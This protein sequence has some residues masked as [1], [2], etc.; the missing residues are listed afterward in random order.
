[1]K[2]A[3]VLLPLPVPE[4]FDYEVP[5][6]LELARGDQ[7]AVPLGPRLM[8][9]IVSEVRETTGSNRRLK[10]VA[11]RLTDPPVPEGALDFVE[12][13]ANEAAHV[14]LV[15]FIWAENIE[16]LDADDLRENFLV[17]RIEVEELLR[18]SVEVERTEAREIFGFVIHTG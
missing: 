5:E 16:I 4:A 8:R 17:V 9:G 18:V 14:A 12:G 15:V 11:Q 7:V 2:V 6:A 1:V 10:A 13:F 3:S